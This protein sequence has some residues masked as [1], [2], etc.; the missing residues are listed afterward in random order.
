MSARAEAS[1]RL[2]GEIVESLSS[3]LLVV[4]SDGQLRILNPA[5][6]R[7]LSRDDSALAKPY[8]EVLPA[9]AR[10]ARRG[11]SEQGEADRPPDA[12]GQRGRSIAGVS[13]RQRLAA[14]ER[15]GTAARRHLPVHRSDARRGNGRA[16]AIE[17]EPRA[18]RRA[19]GRHRARVPQR[20]GDDSRLRAAARSERAARAVS[21]ASPRNPSGDRGAGRG[22][23]EFPEFRQAGAAR[24]SRRSIFASSPNAP[25]TKCAPRRARA[26]ATSSSAESFRSSRA[27]MCC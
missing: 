17:G 15:P 6:R 26:A 5:G 7:L 18:G 4:A 12:A 23:D 9:R 24:R 13:R 3:G 25:P 22:R 21:P 11:V 14:L 2:S 10:A 19:D 27:T 8:R 20:P 16:A 1:E